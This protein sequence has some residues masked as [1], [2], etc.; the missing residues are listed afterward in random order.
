MS[1]PSKRLSL[2]VLKANNE[3]SNWS[4]A[5]G[6]EPSLL[7][8]ALKVAGTEISS[9]CVLKRLSSQCADGKEKE[10]SDRKAY[11]AVAILPSTRCGELDPHLHISQ[12]LIKTDASKI[13][14]A[15]QYISVDGRPLSSIRGVGQE[16]VKIFKNHVR[17]AAS[18]IET[19]NPV[20]D[21]FL[22]LHILCPRGSYDVNIEPAKDDILFEDR[23]L[24]LH[25][26]EELF[27]EHYGGLDG[28]MKSPSDQSKENASRYDKV[29]GGFEL[30]MARK[31]GTDLV[32]RPNDSR[33]SLSDTLPNTPLSHR[34]LHSDH[35]IPPAQ[36]LDSE[37]PEVPEIPDL[38][39]ST[40]AKGSRF[41]N[42]WSISRINASFQTPRRESVSFNISSPVDLSSGSL[43]GLMRRP[44][45]SGSL[46]HSPN[47]SNLPSPATSRFSSGSPV[48]PR[49]Q[50]E[51]E[52]PDSS[53][54]DHRMSSSRRAERER[55][56]ARYGNGALDTWF[57]RTTQ[58]SLQQKPF[59]DITCQGPSELPLSSLA[60][61]RFGSPAQA[62]QDGVCDDEE[63]D[64][65]S[66]PSSQGSSQHSARDDTMLLNSQ[67]GHV[68]V[69]MDSGRGFPVLE[70]WAAQLREDG[71]LKEPSDLEKA[72]DFEQRKKEAIQSRRLQ[73]KNG[74][75]PSSSQPAT[76]SHPTQSSRYLAA[77][78]A[79]TSAK[80]L[81]GEPVSAS[82]LSPHDPRAYLMRHQE[83]SVEKGS[84]NN[85]KARRL[86]TSRLPFER[87]PDGSDLHDLSMTC[88][89]DLSSKSICFRSRICEDSFI[90]SGNEAMAFSVSDVENCL[91]FWNERLALIMKQQYQP[92]DN[93][94]LPRSTIDLSSI[95]SQ[96][97]KRFDAD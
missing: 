82:K 83:I 1:Q 91:P 11:E 18:K 17:A 22:C 76:I 95:I 67:D 28:A 14:N 63:N 8:A 60:Q 21:P 10:S 78:A 16:V 34:L 29:S 90:K 35:D 45:E 56:R 85:A 88:T 3:N 61:E 68:T 69:S 27:R 41:V 44:S 6:A 55:D 93:S 57:Q 33:H 26:V 48:R 86:L 2:K 43:Q 7:D 9:F 58:V 32:T 75:R 96:H 51:Q 31:P 77:K 36:V 89:I 38:S 74:E 54:E 64:G 37:V 80:P 81:I 92:K 94:L 62:A 59:E 72:L 30:L 65:C 79:L 46:Q 40:R 23:G 52:L 87:I 84:V 97:L 19:S 39:D 50:Q 49:R 13:N 15:G 5:P 20:S 24:V 71:G 53:P 25:L 42:P 66:E 12:P 70:R 47:G 4:Y 73:F